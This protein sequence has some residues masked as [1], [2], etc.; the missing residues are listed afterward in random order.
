M[1]G[2]NFSIENGDIKSVYKSVS[3]VRIGAEYHLTDSFSLRGGLEFLGNPYKSSAYG[4]SNPT[5]ITNS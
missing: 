5:W 4:V 2:D 1:G 3:N